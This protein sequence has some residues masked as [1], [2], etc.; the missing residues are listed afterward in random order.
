[1]SHPTDRP[2]AVFDCN[3]LVQAV[4]FAGSPAAK[5]LRLVESNQ[6]EHFI[7]KA[8]VAESRRVLAY[9]EVLA[10]SPNMTPESKRTT[11]FPR[12]R[13]RFSPAHSN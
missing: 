4:A 6:V 2:R 11:T 7:S 13:G 9:D 8:T 3:V 5:C 12:K 1:M 10:I